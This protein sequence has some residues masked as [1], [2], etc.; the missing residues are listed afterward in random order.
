MGATRG[1]EKT[2]TSL[3]REKLRRSKKKEKS[4]VIKRKTQDQKKKGK[5]S[6]WNFQIFRDFFLYRRGGKIQ[7]NKGKV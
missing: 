3:D 6:F 7:E 2:Y 1:I 4:S 5:I